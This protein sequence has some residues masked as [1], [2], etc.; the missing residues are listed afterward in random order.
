MK[1]CLESLEDRSLPSTFSSGQA[2]W[3]ND[4]AAGLD[5]VRGIVVGAVNLTTVGIEYSV[6]AVT[7]HGVVKVTVPGTDL[8]L[9][10]GF[11]P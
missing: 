11:P 5:H 7:G 8:A 6:S 3:I 10:N 4:P 2:V 9:I 1:P